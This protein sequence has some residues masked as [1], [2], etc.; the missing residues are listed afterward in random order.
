LF[1]L[2]FFIFFYLYFYIFYIYIMSINVTSCDCCGIGQ[3][4]LFGPIGQQGRV[5][6]KGSQGLSGINGY[7]GGDG[8]QGYVGRRGPDGYYG[9]SIQGPSGSQGPQGPQGPPGIGG[10]VG[11]LGLIG[12]QGA[13][14]GQG[15]Q[16]AQGIVGDDGVSSP[17]GDI[18]ALG[19]IGH[20]GLTGPDGSPI[21]NFFYA[22]VANTLNGP[23][24]TQLEVH[25]GDELRL[26]SLGGLSMSLV[27]GSALYTIEPNNILSSPGVPISKP[28]DPSRPVLR[29]NS[30]NGALYLWD[31]NLAGGSWEQ[32][33]KSGGAGSQGD[34]GNRGIK[35]NQGPR[36]FQGI[37][38]SGPVGPTGLAVQGAQGNQGSNLL[39]TQGPIGQNIIG[40]TGYPGRMIYSDLFNSTHIPHTMNG[41]ATLTLPINYLVPGALI[42]VTNLSPNG[43]ILNI[44]SGPQII[45][46]NSLMPGQGFFWY[47]YA[48][49]ST[50]TFQCQSPSMMFYSPKHSIAS[51]VSNYFPPYQITSETWVTM[52]FINYGGNLRGLVWDVF[53]GPP[54][55]YTSP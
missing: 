8:L 38:V 22:Q 17:D 26:S 25:S 5:G 43:T 53:T 4:G 19:A 46:F 45:A 33:T 14:G 31:P 42:E 7:S 1:L 41:G 44:P 12:Y 16:G 48:G 40:P 21:N 27:A 11:G 55:T 20:R 32:K 28:A 36:G 6:S 9:A 51:P 13:Q 39:G 10:S 3:T 15:P 23:F 50:N 2:C 47:I 24:L 37:A 18:G 49:T 30:T 52:L 34:E 54:H 35:G 29:M